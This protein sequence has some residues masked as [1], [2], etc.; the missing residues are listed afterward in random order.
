MLCF[1]SCQYL[2]L[3]HLRMSPRTVSSNTTNEKLGSAKTENNA[4][5]K[6]CLVWHLYIHLVHF[7]NLHFVLQP[8]TADIAVSTCLLGEKIPYI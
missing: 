7:S 3:L 8:G 1:L 5:F 6:Q 4:I 2:H